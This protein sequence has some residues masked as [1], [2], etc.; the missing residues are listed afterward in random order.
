MERRWSQID[1]LGEGFAAKLGKKSKS[2]Q[3]SDNQ[4]RDPLGSLASM[5]ILYMMRLQCTLQ[6]G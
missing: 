4:I 1:Q 6:S 3:S 2:R 5:I